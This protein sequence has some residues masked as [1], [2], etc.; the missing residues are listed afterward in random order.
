[1][2]HRSSYLVMAGGGPPSTTCKGSD[3]IVVDDG[4]WLHARRTKP[5]RAIR[6]PLPRVISVLVTGIGAG[7][8]PP[9]QAHVPRSV[10]VTSTGTTGHEITGHGDDETR[11]D[12]T[13]ARPRPPSALS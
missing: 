12:G 8:V 7:N 11:D 5:L 3:I 4:R 9:N 6:R 10:P 13:A 2:T 1:M